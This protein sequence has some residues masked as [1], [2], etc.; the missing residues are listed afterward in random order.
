MDQLYFFLFHRRRRPHGAA[1]MI[2]SMAF[3]NFDGDH[4]SNTDLVFC[5]LCQHL[6]GGEWRNFRTPMSRAK[7]FPNNVRADF[8]FTKSATFFFFRK[9]VSPFGSLFSSVPK[10][11]IT[12]SF[13]HCTSPST[14]K[15]NNEIKTGVCF[16]KE[17]R[18]EKIPAV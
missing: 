5:L 6:P 17:K 2:R 3:I 12:S 11:K 10:R 1:E 15:K 9:R 13:I 16:V 7:L 14:Q 18:T 4:I 8:F